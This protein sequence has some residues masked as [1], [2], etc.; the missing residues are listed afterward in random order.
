MR[1]VIVKKAYDGRRWVIVK[2]EDYLWD[3]GYR[4]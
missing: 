1:G 2:A 4:Y 3:R